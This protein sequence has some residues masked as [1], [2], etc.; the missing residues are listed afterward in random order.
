MAGSTITAVGTTEIN[1]TGTANTTIGNT[2]VGATTVTLNAGTTGNLVM[3]GVDTDASPT[4]MLTL[5]SNNEVRVT[6]LSGTADQGVI[7][8]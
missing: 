2:A 7:Y 1:V 5:N 8:T 4:Q 3:G 6:T